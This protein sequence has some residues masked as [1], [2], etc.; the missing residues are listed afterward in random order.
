MTLYSGWNDAVITIATDNTVSAAVKLDKPYEYLN[1]IIPTID[2]A[3]VS[4]MVAPTE[5]GTYVTLG[6]SATTTASTGAFADTFQLG[7]YQF[8]KIKTSATQTANR[9]F[10]IRGIRL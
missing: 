5:A 9:T 1:V 8:V 3:T 4:L 10:Q 6:Q 7:G 2:S